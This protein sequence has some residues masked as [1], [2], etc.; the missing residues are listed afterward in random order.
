MDNETVETL[1]QE[2]AIETDEHIQVIE[3][4]LASISG[5]TLPSEEIAT[6]FRSFHSLKGLARA[7]ALT[8]MEVVAHRCETLLGQV[9]DQGRAFDDDTV[10]AL[11]EAVDVLGSLRDQAVHHRKDGA[12]PEGLV[13]RLEDLAAAGGAPVGPQTAAAP[14]VSA[15]ATPAGPPP[16]VADA[17]MAA[18]FAELVSPLL[19]DLG[20]VLSRRILAHDEPPAAEKDA[21]KLLGSL[22][23]AATVMGFYNV[24]MLL[25]ALRRRLEGSLREPGAVSAV[26]RIA[27]ELGEDLLLI[28]RETGYDPGSV[29]FR[30]ALRPAADVALGSLRNDLAQAFAVF[31]HAADEAGAA[32]VGG[33]AT[34]FAAASTFFTT[35]PHEADLALLI[36]DV[37]VRYAHGGLRYEAPLDGVVF[38]AVQVLQG[39]HASSV[40]SAAAEGVRQALVHALGG[41]ETAATRDLVLGQLRKDGVPE[42]LL[43]ALTPENL[44]DAAEAFSAGA[45]RAVV[46]EADINSRPDLARAFVEWLRGVGHPITNRTLF[47]DGQTMFQF[48]VLSNRDRQ[49]IIDGLLELDHGGSALRLVEP[50]GASGSAGTAERPD[51]ASRD[52]S[53]RVTVVRVPGETIDLFL[54]QIGEMVLTHSALTL[55]LENERAKT[56]RAEMRR[57]IDLTRRGDGLDATALTQ[58]AQLLEALDEQADRLAEAEQQL[59][60]GLQRLQERALDLRVLPIDTVF[61]RFP[62]VV[63][64]I[65]KQTGKTVRLDLS[66]RE[67]RI[68]KGMVELLVDPLMHMVRNA[69]D[70]GIEAPEERHAVGKPETGVIRLEGQQRGNHVVIEITDDGRGLDP[71]RLRAKAVERGLLSESQAAQM[72]DADAY[73]LIF[74]P[75]FSMAAKVTET[76][77]RGVG[78]DVVHTNVVGRLGGRIDITSQ[79]GRGS[80]FTLTLPLSAAIQ[81]AL[82][83]KAGRQVLA[84]PDRYLVEVQDVRLSEIQTVRGQRALLLRNSFLPVFRLTELL[85]GEGGAPPEGQECAPVLVVSNGR[86]R[87]GLEVDR[88]FRRQELYVK[89]IHPRLAAIPGVGGASVLGDGRVVLILDIDDLFRLATTDDF[90]TDPNQ[91]AVQDAP[92]TAV[93][94][95]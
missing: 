3:P 15:A 28:D 27:C 92:L 7:M 72:S 33:V 20:G 54:S 25:Q 40:V 12:R 55:A 30:E 46:I 4:L 90:S 35:A 2:F 67:A 74:R 77:G 95:E 24:A 51:S 58:V 36:A 87:M 5:P 61:N 21:V 94:A 44:R 43:A 48:V 76:S 52:E 91:L 18:Y 29:A 69:V 19:A 23:H 47:R 1:W 26:A 6:L 14:K 17:D 81:D 84:V 78:M 39:G 45:G 68:D 64:D 31:A 79:L 59:H 71:N 83:V 37:L 42:E 63:R 66:K 8:A 60:G 38:Q 49:D 13:A 11:L 80:T 50:P 89:D 32:R 75:G 34:A 65:A 88:L 41:T 22:D 9:R 10:S 62:R 57:L 82:L 16:L 93:A 73:H 70:H 56:A 85:G 53:K 86:L